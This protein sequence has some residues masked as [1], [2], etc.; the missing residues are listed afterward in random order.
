[1]QHAEMFKERLRKGQYLTCAEELRHWLE[2]APPND[3][4]RLQALLLRCEALV[5]NPSASE[6][7]L[8]AANELAEAARQAGCQLSLAT[9]ACHRSVGSRRLG[10]R[11]EASQQALTAL[12]L[13][14]EVG[15][16]A[17][18]SRALLIAARLPTD[19]G[20]FAEARHL[21]AQSIACAERDGTSSV[22]FWPLNNLSH[23]IGVEAADLAAAGDRDA[24]R[25][26]VVELVEIVD[27]ALAL[28]RADGH[29]LQEA[30]ALSN[31]ADAYIVEGDVVRA[32]ELIREYAGLARQI[33][34]SRLQAYAELDE[35]RLLRAA[36]KLD[37]AIAIL[38]SPSLV[39]HLPGN[40]DVDRT[41][42]QTLYELNK[43][44]GRYEL[45]LMFHEQLAKAQAALYADRSA[46]MQRV[47]LAKLDLESAQAQAERARLEAVSE[48]LRS[49]VLERERDQHLQA[50]LH[51]PLTGLANRRAAEAQWGEH[52]ERAARDGELF[53]AAI[54]DIDHF[55]RVNDTF[56]HAKGD[57]VLAETGRVLH[58][59]LRR[60][61]GLY[62][63]GGEEFLALMTDSTPGAGIAA[64]ER[65]RAGIAAID[66]SAI[67]PGLQVTVSIGVACRQGTETQA[68]LLERAD[69]AL[70][71][72]KA[73]GRNRCVKA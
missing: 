58:G 18:E 44:L 71:A 6:E 12:R 51:D 41:R 73:A 48:R 14:R 5:E 7:L 69:A 68:A 9:A 39:Q 52:A 19:E 32:R 66:W 27:R 31:L 3:P 25:I 30:F 26:K 37:E 33:G 40:E 22:L 15:N 70:Y 1:M 65:L 2:Q 61:D 45:A 28:A 17:L 46:R 63:M 56:G 64:C 29:V 35:V 50:A 60:R 72:A 55:K 21:L 11:E 54:I 23:I 57:A 8:G 20:D 62:R 59:L 36:G 67:V 42:I 13:A 49:Q 38:V 53:F 34:F 24:A 43:M 10:L 47:L 16:S 4:G